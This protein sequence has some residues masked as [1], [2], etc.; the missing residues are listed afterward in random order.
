MEE[1]AKKMAQLLKVLANEHRLLILCILIQGSENVGN[2]EKKI[3]S[4]SQSALSQNLSLMKAHGIV[5]STKEGQHIV[6]SIADHRVKEIIDV[7]KQY[8][9]HM[10]NGE[11]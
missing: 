10:E 3:G 4:I 8:Y 2:I 11:G 1:N 6:Y 9:C 5:E 7:I